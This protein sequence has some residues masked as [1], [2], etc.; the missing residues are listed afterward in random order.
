MCSENFS[1]LSG[2]T[3]S[4]GDASAS[5][6]GPFLSSLQSASPVGNPAS[7]QQTVN[8]QTGKHFE[9][10][11]VDKS[12]TAPNNVNEAAPSDDKQGSDISYKANATIWGRE[13]LLKDKDR[14]TV[15]II[16][17]KTDTLEND[18]SKYPGVVFPGYHMNHKTWIS[19]M[20]SD[21]LEDRMIMEYV[22]RSFELTK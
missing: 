11:P 21:Y 9:E 8:N 15:D 12:T 22:Q 18:I 17:L 7:D 6:T 4:P 16:N 14:T 13:K 19:I 3:C 1:H 2:K 20:L 5:V 10:P